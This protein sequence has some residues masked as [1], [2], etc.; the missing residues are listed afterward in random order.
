MGIFSGVVSSTGSL[1]FLLQ[2]THPTRFSRNTVN[3]TSYNDQRKRLFP[4]RQHR[5]W[6][7]Q[8]SRLENAETYPLVT[9]VI[10]TYNRAVLLP[11]AISSVL[12][13]TY[14][15]IEIVIADDGSTD[16]T[17]LVVESFRDARLHFIQIPHSG[18]P[19]RV[20]N[21]GVKAGK[22]SWIAFLDS[23]DV[24]MPYKLEMQIDALIKYRLK[25]SY[26]NFAHFTGGIKDKEGNLQ[27][28]ELASITTASGPQRPQVTGEITA[29]ILR[30]EIAVFIGTVILE[31]EL[32][33][34]LN[35]FNESP[36]LPFRGD[37]EFVLRLSLREAGIGLPGVLALVRE[38]EERSTGKLAAAHE[39]TSRVYEL[40]LHE[41]ISDKL[42]RIALSRNA[43][44]L[45]ES[46]AS[47]KT[48]MDFGQRMNL[49]KRSFRY[50]KKLHWLH[51][52][53]R[54]LKSS[55]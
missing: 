21:A 15:N 5:F 31:R 50:D 3:Y 7:G 4:W 25:W 28:Q 34:Q 23:D 17:R 26:G 16:N 12:A 43:Y 10:P 27:L 1:V 55:W 22:G 19:G 2:F 40:F 44:L 29:G 51:C 45:S 48:D 46:A 39:F 35:G 32:F 38:H 42:R 49:M 6:P 24:W 41:P 54:S 33:D 47:K 18:H 14:P 30:N 53:A 9:V 13:Q 52:L 11:E 8:R 20:R 36:Y 37:L